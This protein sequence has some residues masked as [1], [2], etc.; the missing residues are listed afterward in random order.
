MPDISQ[1]SV[2]AFLRTG[3]VFI[4]DFIT[5]LLLSPKVKEMWENCQHLAKFWTLYRCITSGQFF[6]LPCVLMP[7]VACSAVVKSTVA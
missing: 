4:G 2:T 5:D 6:A 1:S 7:S 3:T